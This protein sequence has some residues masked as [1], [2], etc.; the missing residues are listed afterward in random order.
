MGYIYSMHSED[1]KEAA[2]FRLPFEWEEKSLAGRLTVLTGGPVSLTMT[3]NTVSVLYAKRTRAGLNLRL[4]RIFLKASPEVINEVAR[5]AKGRK[6]GERFPVLSG[7]IKGNSGLLE[8]ERAGKPGRS[9]SAPRAEGK[10]H[11]LSRIYQSV[12]AEYFGG[13]LDCDITWGK[14]TAKRAVRK[15][16]LGCYM[17]PRNGARGLIRINPVLDSGNTPVFYVSF[18]VYHELLHA[19][20]GE[21]KQNGRRI[22]HGA[23]FKRREKLFKDYERAVARETKRIL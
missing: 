3:S 12:N 20:I 23:E 22:V 21:I 7:F 11:D 9:R 5:F 15:Q 13:R 8:K 16:T 19:D 2:Q 4:H 1:H 6:R 18:V 14:R 10:F 17:Y